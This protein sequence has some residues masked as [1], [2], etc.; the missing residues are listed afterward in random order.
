MVA[1]RSAISTSL[2]PTG[3][4]QMVSPQPEQ[5]VMPTASPE[6]ARLKKFYTEQYNVEADAFVRQP[7]SK[8]QFNQGISKLQTKYKLAFNRAKIGI[9]QERPDP[10]FKQY[11]EL[12]IYRGRLE[13]NIKEFR[14]D[15]AHKIKSWYKPKRWEETIPT[16]L[17][18][19][20]P[21]KIKY[22]KEGQPTK[23]SVQGAWRKA[24]PN[25]IEQ[26]GALSNELKRVTAEQT[27]LIRP[28]VTSD[29]MK[30]ATRS[31]R[32]GGAIKDQVSDYLARRE[33]V[34]QRQEPEEIIERGGRRW[35]IV[36]HDTDGTPLVEEVR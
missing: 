12:D 22:D 29:L 20:D 19:F 23:S 9:K 27:E 34:T 24:K 1:R 17:Q 28:E 15:P 6:E 11:S 3:P 26:Y 7:M 31:P 32:M 25:E 5:A 36:G 30:T 2:A 18:I 10:V 14:I 8:V 21:S 35:R 33:T 16:Q 13:G 4:V